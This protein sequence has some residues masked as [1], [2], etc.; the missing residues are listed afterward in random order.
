MFCAGH[1]T[2]LGPYG[3]PIEIQIRTRQMDDMAEKGIAAHWLYKSQGLT[4]Q[5]AQQWLERLTE[6]Q[7]H[8]DS[9]IEFVENVKVDL[10]PD[11]VFVFTPT[12][13]I[14][15][16]PRDA[17]PVDFAYAIHTEIGNTCIASRVNRRMTPLSY[18]L[19]HGE[20]VEV[21]TSP[22]ASPNPAWLNFV[23]TG[24]AKSAIRQ[25]IR[26]QANDEAYNL[27]K[28]LV[29][30]FLALHK[31]NIDQSLNDAI[32]DQLN[33][34][35]SVNSLKTLLIKI[36]RGEIDPTEA[37]KFIFK[38]IHDK[39]PR[40]KSGTSI[41][42]PA[43]MIYGHDSTNISFAQ[44]CTPIPGDKIVGVIIPNQG[45][46]IHHKKC[47]FLK[48]DK[49]I[50]RNPQQVVRA[51]WSQNIDKTF[52]CQLQIEIANYPGAIADMASTIGNLSLNIQQINVDES[53]EMY[54]VVSMIIKV[55]GRIELAKALR[56]LKRLPRVYRVARKFKLL[57]SAD[58]FKKK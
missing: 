48:K 41:F 3:I 44:C 32:L 1:T 56:A 25:Y 16:L 9:S 26:E 51:E 58:D 31:L 22:T 54:G 19:V 14:I 40:Y 13:E 33:H 11:E 36:G 17:T 2:L 50:K 15:E 12:G 52:N 24:K 47:P 43:L 53:D 42:S 6:I 8:T 57:K 29:N 38:C 30:R 23:K 28:R 35:Y 5:K 39:E 37:A 4:E 55:T 21:I 20:T 34:H 10:F 49:T 7:E 46:I 45:L 27:G 18:T